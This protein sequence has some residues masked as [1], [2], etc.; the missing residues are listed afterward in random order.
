VVDRRATKSLFLSKPLIV[1][2]FFAIT[3]LESLAALSPI[4]F[5][6]DNG[7]TWAS[8]KRELGR[9]LVMHLS[10]DRADADNVSMHA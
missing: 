7:Y 5:S 3:N 8:V 6:I 10:A 1:S 2:R 9:K 4:L